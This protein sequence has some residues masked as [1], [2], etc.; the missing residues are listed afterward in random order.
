MS[1]ISVLSNQ[2]NLLVD[3]SQKV[4]QSVVVYKKKWLLG[5]ADTKSKYPKLSVSATDTKEAKA[6]L[7][8]FLNNLK[9][10]LEEDES[11]SEYIPSIVLKDYRQKLKDKQF[12][13]DDLPPLI[14][15][16][17]KEKI[18]SEED[19]EVLDTILSVLDSERTALFRKIRT[20]RG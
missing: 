12:I 19:I 10:I 20:A 6:V 4:N 9:E 17:E 1:E 16:I 18:S 13:K 3:T 11:S 2:Y 7:V 5:E 8:P 14:E 15:N